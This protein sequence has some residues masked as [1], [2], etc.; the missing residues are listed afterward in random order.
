MGLVLFG[1]RSFCVGRDL[2]GVQH[3][4]GL[5]NNLWAGVLFVL[6]ESDREVVPPRVVT[7]HAEEKI[8]RLGRESH[9]LQ[10]AQAGV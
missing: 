1:L 5:V 10:G 6:L 3:P 4:K 2:S 7:R 8:T 9:R